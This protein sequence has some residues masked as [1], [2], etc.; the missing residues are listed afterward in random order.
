MYK[1]S[2]WQTN[3]VKKGTRVSEFINWHDLEILHAVLEQGSFSGAARTLGLSQPTVSRHID[4]L[5]RRLGKE[6]FARANGT[7]EPSDLARNLGEHTTGMNEGMFA[8]RRVL[9]G[10]E[11]KPQGIVNLSLPYGFGGMV[12]VE[13]LADFHLHY[14]GISI[15]L[16]LG[17]PQ[18]NLGRR[19]ADIDL[20]WQAPTEPEIVHKRL[21]SFHM[22]LFAAQ[23]Y[24]ERH[25]EP[26]SHAELV[27]HYF[28]YA[29]EGIMQLILDSLDEHGGRPGRFPFRC[30]GNLMLAATMSIMGVTINVFPLT[31]QPATLVRL[32]PAYHFT[33]PEFW[34]TMHSGLRRNSAIR[35][36]WDWLVDRM[37]PLLARTRAEAEARATSG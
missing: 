12:L 10:A 6:L 2:R 5:E 18:S 34:L 14:P 22:G 33:S 27:D 36:V 31:L 13:V 35:A 26:R 3:R 28:P 37:P 23:S 1:N 30:S 29:D 8:I 24:I 17:P 16:K 20:R 9:D 4:G 7:L 15:D 21:G 19:E 32:L 11:E 25:G